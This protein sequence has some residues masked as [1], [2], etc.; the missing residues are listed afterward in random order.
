L[1]TLPPT[2]LLSAWRQAKA[3]GNKLDN[4][5]KALGDRTTDLL[6]HGAESLALVWESAWRE[7]R[8]RPDARPLAVGALGAVDK[9]ALM[10]LYN[11]PAGFIPSMW[12]REMRDAVMTASA[13]ATVKTD[14]RKGSRASTPTPP[15]EVR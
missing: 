5:W 15:V 13:A 7:G 3:G 2:E 14:R 12:L 8:A 11:D 6:A 9:K 10:D 1:K 4:L